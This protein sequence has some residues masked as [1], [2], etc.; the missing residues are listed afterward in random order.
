MYL[1]KKTSSDSKHLP[2]AGLHQGLLELVPHGAVDQEVRRGIDDKQPV[3]ETC[4]TEVPVGWGVGGG[5]PK[6]LLHHEELGTV[7]DDPGDVTEEEDHDNTDE[8]SGK[9]HFT[10]S[11][12][13]CLHVRKSK[14]I[15]YKSFPC[16]LV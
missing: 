3:V 4:Q 6:H 11:S 12:L 16:F 14:R 15:S 1:N 10:V 7:E 13:V 5:A 2:L 8:D 9:V